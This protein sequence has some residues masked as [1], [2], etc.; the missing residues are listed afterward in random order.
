MKTVKSDKCSTNAESYN[1]FLKQDPRFFKSLKNKIIRVTTKDGKKHV[2]RV[3]AVDPVTNAILSIRIGDDIVIVNLFPVHSIKS[4]MIQHAFA[5]PE[6]YINTG[7]SAEN[8][9]KK[10]MDV[11]D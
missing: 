6:V 8:L 9:N 1:P 10:R 3:Y 11:K 2:G 4:L 7:V 5:P